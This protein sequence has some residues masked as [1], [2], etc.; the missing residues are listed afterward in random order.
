MSNNNYNEPT[1]DDIFDSLEKQGTKIPFGIHTDCTLNGIEITDE[2]IDLHFGDSKGRTH[3]SRMWA[4]NGKFP[5]DGETVNDAIVREK[6]DNLSQLAKL[7]TIFSDRSKVATTGTDY[8]SKAKA[9]AAAVLPLK[10]T[11]KLNLKL[12]YDSDGVYSKFPKW[13][14]F[15]EC[16]EGQAPTLK[17]TD[18][19][20][21]NNCTP[22][23]QPQG[24]GTPNPDDIF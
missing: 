3:N 19:E 10:D 7:V 22:K 6:K 17:Y 11:K 14:Y 16:V 1:L 13:G 9:M 12:I 15:E 24:Q 21:N 2:Y 20:Q 18:Y 23:A 5:R 4:P 8:I